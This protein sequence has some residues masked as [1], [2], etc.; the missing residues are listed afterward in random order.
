MSR[1]IH[2]C[3]L[4]TLPGTGQGVLDALTH[5][6]FFCLSCQRRSAPTDDSIGEPQQRCEKCGQATLVW[7]PPAISPAKDAL[8]QNRITQFPT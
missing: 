8:N 3:R 7:H 5:G 2:L 1:P 4:R 6:F